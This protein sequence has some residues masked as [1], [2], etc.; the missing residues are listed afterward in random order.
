MTD[1]TLHDRV[2]ALDDAEALDTLAEAPSSPTGDPSSPGIDIRALR[3]SGRGPDG[4]FQ[5]GHLVNLRHGLRVRPEHPGIVAAIGQRH[6]AIRADLGDQM[7]AIEAPLAYE[8]ARVQAFTASAGEVLAAQG[9]TTAKGA[10]RSMVAI[11][12][13][14]LE[15]QI[16]LARMLGLSRRAKLAGVSGIVAQ[17]RAA[18]GQ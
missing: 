14:L 12:E 9:L 3:E 5:R 15:K 11:Y 2:G 1:D 8:L 4:K 13:R 17:V 10:A 16:T 6:E 7:T 18:D